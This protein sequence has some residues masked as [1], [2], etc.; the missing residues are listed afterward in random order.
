MSRRKQ[1]A[2]KL[3]SFFAC[4]ANGARLVENPFGTRNPAGM[5]FP[6]ATRPLRS[7]A[8]FVLLMVL[9]S[10]SRN[11]AAPQHE[12]TLVNRRTVSFR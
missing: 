5:P 2:A 10:A 6:S 3:K 8:R 1:V 7:I 12:Q 4:R 11:T 9:V